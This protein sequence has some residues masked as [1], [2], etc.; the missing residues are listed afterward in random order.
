MHDPPNIKRN[1]KP[2]PGI[3]FTAPNLPQLIEDCIALGK[4]RQA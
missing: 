3:T 1:R 2:A 4:A